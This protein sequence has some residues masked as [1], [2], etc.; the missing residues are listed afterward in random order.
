MEGRQPSCGGTVQDVVTDDRRLCGVDVMVIDYD[1]AGADETYDFPQKARNDAVTDIATAC[2]SY[3]TISAASGI[4]LADLW[5]RF[6]LACP[7]YE[8][9]ERPYEEHHSH[10]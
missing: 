3:R 6:S 1:T 5:Q 9:E 10:A 7:A 8:R 4:D 2:L